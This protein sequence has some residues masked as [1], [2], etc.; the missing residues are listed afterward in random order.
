M[1]RPT[2]KHS[3]P[4]PIDTII[5]QTQAQ[6]QMLVEDRAMLRGSSR[7]LSPT[8]DNGQLT[9]SNLE[10]HDYL[11]NLE[12]QVCCPFDIPVK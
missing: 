3:R 5:M 2:D 11:V 9:T 1:S 12:Q 8:H 7:S 4:L 6:T 10:L